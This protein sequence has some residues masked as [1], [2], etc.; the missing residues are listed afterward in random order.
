MLIVCVH[1]QMRQISNT[2]AKQRRKN[3]AWAGLLDTVTV[4]G[5]SL[6]SFTRWRRKLGS[7]ARQI[8]QELRHEPP[9]TQAKLPFSW[10][11][12]DH[13]AVCPLH[14]FFIISLLRPRKEE[15]PLFKAELR[16]DRTLF[17]GACV[18][19]FSAP[20]ITGQL[21]DKLIAMISSPLLI[22]LWR[23]GCWFATGLIVA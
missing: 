3:A 5:S 23:R 13:A 10:K 22:R 19:G 18:S 2:T 12:R 16:R 17:P 9:A 1:F 15:T 6:S 8:S 11:V 20:E 7:R 14:S 21:W 4:A